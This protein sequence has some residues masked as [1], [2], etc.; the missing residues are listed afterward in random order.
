LQATLTR[1]R[2]LTR[3]PARGLDLAFAHALAGNLALARTLDLACLLALALARTLAH[4]RDHTLDRTCALDLDL[5]RT[6]ARALART[7]DL[8][9][10]DTLDIY[11]HFF[12]LQERRARRLPAWE[13]ILL[14]KE[15]TLDV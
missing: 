4:D 13:G 9:R 15:R 6:R 14:V 3:T 11:I 10:A 2:N 8:A 7:L 1:A 5:A 12:L